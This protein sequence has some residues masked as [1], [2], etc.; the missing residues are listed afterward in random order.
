MTL[1]I[2]EGILVNVSGRADDAT[3]AVFVPRV[4]VAHA[5]ALSAEFVFPRLKL[6]QLTVGHF[7]QILDIVPVLL[8]HPQGERPESIPELRLLWP[9]AGWSRA[10]H[11]SDQLLLRMQ[12]TGRT[13]RLVRKVR[14]RLDFF[15]LA[16]WALVARYEERMAQDVLDALP[17]I[18]IDG[19]HQPDDV[20]HLV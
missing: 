18:D 2:L 10:Q 19:K 14:R 5:L 11:L 3:D 7:L 12:H 6:C 17:H 16:V 1:S 20:S 13:E 8:E 15:L 9:S 4:N